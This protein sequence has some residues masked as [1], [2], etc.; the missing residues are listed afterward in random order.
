[1]SLKNY[2]STVSSAQK[3]KVVPPT[4]KVVKNKH[5]VVPTNA[6][7]SGTLETTSSFYS[8]MKTHLIS[9]ENND[10]VNKSHTGEILDGFA[11]TTNI[12]VSNV[13]V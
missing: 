12:S 2:A 3:P 6:L 11:V 10:I 4:S 9:L 13:T 7:H 8:Y 1:M 5:T